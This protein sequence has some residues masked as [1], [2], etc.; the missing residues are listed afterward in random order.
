MT[1]CT[2]LSDRMPAVALATARWSPA[3]ER[4]LAECPACAA[5]WVVVRGGARLGLAVQSSIDGEAIARGVLAQVRRGGAEAGRWRR[6]VPWLIPLAAAAALLLAIG[7]P[8]GTESPTAPPAG[9]LTL[10]PELETLSAAELES[11]LELLPAD[12]VVPTDVRSFE[13]LNEDELSVVL[14]GLEG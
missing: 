4:H 2:R 6:H 13:D 11:M 1:D 12:G 5:E 3:E 14:T 7:L 9:E 10:L 8:R